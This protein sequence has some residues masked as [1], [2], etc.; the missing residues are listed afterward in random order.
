MECFGVC[1][2]LFCIGK[3]F[4]GVKNIVDIKIFCSM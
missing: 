4:F 2:E 1:V 3:V